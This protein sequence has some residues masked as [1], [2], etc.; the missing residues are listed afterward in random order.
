M[1]QA[2]S[3]LYHPSPALLAPALRKNEIKEVKKTTFKASYIQ[4]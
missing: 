3:I 4:K 1:A 2:F